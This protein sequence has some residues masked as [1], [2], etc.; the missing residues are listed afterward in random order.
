[1]VTSRA[2]TGNGELRKERWDEQDSRT[3]IDY[4]RFFVPGREEQIAAFCDL[5]SAAVEPAAVPPAPPSASPADSDLR[6]VPHVYSRTCGPVLVEL[7]CGEGLLARALLER[8]PGA[9]VFGYDG[10]QAMLDSAAAALAAFGERFA[11]CLFDLADCSWRGFETLPRAP[12]AIVSSLAIHHLDGAAKRALFGDLFRA[13]APGGLLLIADLVRPA[14]AA[15]AALA[16]RAWD[17]AVRQ[18]ALALAGNLDPLEVFRRDRWNY[19]ADPDP[20]PLDRP[21]PL[22]DQLRWLG[23][24]GFGAVDVY[25]MKAG[26]A[27]FGGAKPA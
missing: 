6:E 24:A 25:W 12:R 21:S 23:E 16:A 5:V 15:G 11:T 1:M 4:S 27:L 9:T 18:R 22:T 26:H 14:T 13:F 10:S 19:F 7:C 17:D 8:L 3:F 2:M 20:D